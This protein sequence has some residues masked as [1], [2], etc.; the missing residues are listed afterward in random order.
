MLFTRRGFAR[1]YGYSS[2]RWVG[3]IDN[4]AEGTKAKDICNK[5]KKT[6][7]DMEREHEKLQKGVQLKKKELHIQ[8]DEVFRNVDRFEY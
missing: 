4:W 1:R 6:I 3:T 2:Y 8:E 5:L 7:A